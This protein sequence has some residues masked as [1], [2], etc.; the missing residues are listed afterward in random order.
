MTNRCIEC[1]WVIRINYSCYDWIN[2][3]CNDCEQEYYKWNYE[4]YSCLSLKERQELC[5][6]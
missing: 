1:E 4:K 2:Y 6:T 3:I 5:K